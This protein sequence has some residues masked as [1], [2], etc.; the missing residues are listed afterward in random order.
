MPAS[1][2]LVQFFLH[3]LRAR[4]WIAGVFLI[5]T[6]A[7]IYGSLQVPDDPA[8]EGLIVPGDP[9]ARA[10]FEFERL[11][12]EGAQAL[13]MLESRDPLSLAALRA[14]DQL[15]HDLAKIPQV[16]AHSLLDLYRRG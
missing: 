3:V 14:A 5:L 11:F 16:E 1:P 4:R 15:E 13:L 7:G 12:P 6:A 9:V 2:K 8:I 10:T